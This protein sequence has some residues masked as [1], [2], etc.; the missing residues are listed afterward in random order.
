MRSPPSR[1][2]ER[3]QRSKN[4]TSKTRTARQNATVTINFFLHQIG[5]PPRPTLPIAGLFYACGACRLS[6]TPSLYRSIEKRRGVKPQSDS[7]RQIQ[8]VG[9]NLKDNL[10]AMSLFCPRHE[11]T[12][13]PSPARCNR[14][15]QGARDMQ[16]PQN[17]RLEIRDV[18]VDTKEEEKCKEAKGMTELTETTTHPLVT[19]IGVV[20]C[21]HLVA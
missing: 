14:C 9:P 12:K 1:A 13:T 21:Y 6:F 20:T 17:T 4:H 15:S 10:S 18:C 7:D 2:A 19:T 8:V 3:V 16:E 5:Q 11:T